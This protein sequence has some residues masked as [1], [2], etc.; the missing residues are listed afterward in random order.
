MEAWGDPP[1]PN[2]KRGSGDGGP[3]P[4]RLDAP[5][6]QDPPN[7][8]LMQA[9]REREA[10]GRPPLQP[11]LQAQNPS[12]LCYALGGTNTVLSPPK[13]TEF[14]GQTPRSDGLPGMM[15]QLALRSPNQV[16]MYPNE[17]I[18]I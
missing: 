14:L 10:L 5:H 15:R 16:R 13:M 3:P 11:L 2:K 12:R 6:F 9:M 7:T 17:C 4:K 1:L 18:L 8:P